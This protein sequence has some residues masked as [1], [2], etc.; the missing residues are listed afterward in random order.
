M[1]LR[2]FKCPFC[3]YRFRA[4]PEGRY[5]VGITDVVRGRGHDR[6]GVQVPHRGDLI[7]PNCGQLYLSPLFLW[8]VSLLAA[9]LVFFP[10]TYASNISSWRESRAAFERIVTWKHTALKVAGGFWSWVLWPCS[11]P[12]VLI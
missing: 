3:G 11:P 12:W 9:L 8:L 10:R 7:C 6:L 1:T 2:V 5:E 4:D